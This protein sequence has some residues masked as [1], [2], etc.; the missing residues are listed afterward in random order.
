M[1]RRDESRNE[2]RAQVLK[3]ARKLIAA[4]GVEALTMR[5]L[6]AES[7][8]AVNTIYAIFGRSRDDVLGALVHDGIAELDRRLQPQENGLPKGGANFVATIV[9]YILEEPRVFRPVLLAEAH[10]AVGWGDA[11]A[12]EH[13]RQMLELLVA[14][15]VVREGTDIEVLGEHI[16][17]NFRIL[18]WRW[19]RYEIGDD[20]FRARWLYSTQLA[21]VAVASPESRAAFESELEKLARKARRLRN[22]RRKEQST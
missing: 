10:A 1:S 2:R 19:A 8:V 7:G 16:F 20:E 12:I 6:A 3:A 18:S 21:L 15:G 4:G 9:D 13:G 5:G 14:E 11:A 17:Q 22:R